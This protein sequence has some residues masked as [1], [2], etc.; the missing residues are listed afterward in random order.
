[1]LFSSWLRNSK[2]SAPAARRR[3]PTSPRPRASFRPRLEAIEDRCL[4]STAIVQTNLVSDDTQ[5]TPAEVQDPNL[6]NPWGLAAGPTGEWWVANEGTG[7]STLYNTSTSPLDDRLAGR[8]HSAQLPGLSARYADRYRLQ[9]QRPGVRRLR[10]RPDRLQRLPVRHRRRHHLRLESGGR[11]HPC[12]R[13]GDQ[14]RRDRPRPGHRHGLQPRR[15]AAVRGRFR[16]GHHRRLRS[17]LPIGNDPARQLHRP[18]LAGRLLSVQH[19]GHQQ[20]ALRRVRP[21]R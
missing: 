14:P 12:H 6:V 18:Q 1:M 4:L 16:Q 11:L 21:G 7:T 10:E 3:T 5:F 15:N 8:Q 20:S 13:R 17:E 2:R 19:P 9:H